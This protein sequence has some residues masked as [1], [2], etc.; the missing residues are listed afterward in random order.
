MIES[1]RS[2]RLELLVDQKLDHVLG[3][4]DADITL[5]EYG[6][7]DCPGCRAANE[8]TAGLRDKFGERLRYV[9][10]HLSV[11]DSEIARRAAELTERAGDHDLFWSIHVDLMT[12]S[13]RLTEGDLRSVT[14]KLYESKAKGIS[15][16]KL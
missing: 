3:S 11:L 12:R 5:V 1:Q 13:N 7:Y 15:K 9:F 14:K 16:A 2:I 8:L 10:R 4:E 6:S